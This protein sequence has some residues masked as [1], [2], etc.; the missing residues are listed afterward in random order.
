[1]TQFSNLG[2]AEPILRAVSA[3]GYTDPTPIQA[4]VIPAMMAGRDVLGTAQTGTG[5]TAAFV[6]PLLNALSGERRRPEPK[7]CRALILAPTRELAAQ[8]VESAQAYSAGTKISVTMIIGGVKMS[9]QVRAMQRGVDIVVATP[10]R[11]LDLKKQDAI[12]FDQIQSVVLDEADHMMDMG[13][14]PQIRNVLRQLPKVRQTVLLSA[15]MPTD[16]RKLADQF[17]NDPVDIAVAQVSKPVERIE[18]SVRFMRQDQKR[19]ALRDILVDE[20]VETAIVFTRTKH[21]AD[22][23]CKHLEADGIR[24]AAIHGNKSQNRRTQAL[25]AFKARDLKVLVATDIAARGIDIERVSHVVNFDLPNVPESYVHRIGR[26][27]RAGESGTAIAF[28]DPSERKLLRD[29]E[30]LIGNRLAGN[31]AGQQD[32]P[33]SEGRERGFR[34]EKDGQRRR[35]PRRRNRSRKAG[36]KAQGNAGRQSS[37]AS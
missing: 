17:L 22:R 12:R 29:I 35:K 8:I 34:P 30:K 31:E 1:M 15:T 14:L 11:L 21:G 6:L 2:L 10:G 16:I 28:C 23:V 9:K 27:A 5:K 3:Q 36:G 7:S 32:E 13:F 24:A 19:D 33:Q 4:Q 18:Q 37:H 25:E 20:N 26:T